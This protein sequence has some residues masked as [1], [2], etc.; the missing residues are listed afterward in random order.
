MHSAYLQKL[1]SVLYFNCIKYIRC[2]CSRLIK[3]NLKKL[4][5]RYLLSGYPAKAAC[6]QLSNGDIQ[7]SFEYCYYIIIASF[8]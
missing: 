5:E 1:L 8:Y 7:V 6:W 2:F 4:S 3:E